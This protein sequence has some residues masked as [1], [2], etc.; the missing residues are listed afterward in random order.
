MPDLKNIP[1]VIILGPT[2]VGK[3][4]CAFDLAQRFGMEIINADSMQ[5]YRG[6]D[7]GSAKPSPCERGL[8][9]HHL[10]DIRDPD[11]EFSAAQFRAEA[12]N[13]IVSL[14]QQGKQALVVGGTGLYIRA[15]TRGL[16]PSPPA[17][18]GL[19]EELKEKGAREGKGYLH[20]ELEKVDPEA[21]L[22]IH[23]NDTFR[24]IRALEIFYLTGTPISRQ[25]QSHQFK[26]CP[27]HVL[28]IGL[29]RD[30][31]ALYHRIEERVATMLA[32]GLLEE[33]NLLLKKGYAPTIKPFHS[34]GY[35]QI[36]GHLQG[37][38]SLDEAAQAIKHNT[39]RYAKRQLTWFRKDTEIEWFTLP[40]Q[41]FEISEAVRK[42]LN[43]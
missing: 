5:V 2:A 9:T 17:D 42:F 12:H 19:R 28:K 39:K 24:T 11:E 15:L 27:F 36:L 21:A 1:L 6:M 40:R 32:S 35:K 22:R 34:L 4:A 13:I 16:F 31:A 10:I 38:T 37:E 23:P 41:S 3:S 43:I 18:R 8:V 14:F 25:H 33:V 30:R 26:E 29:L 20:R 7:I